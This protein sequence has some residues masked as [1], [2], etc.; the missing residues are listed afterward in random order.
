MP[1]AKAPVAANW[2]ALTRPTLIG[3]L[4]RSISQTRSPAQYMARI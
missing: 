1:S 3:F 4:A 2:Y